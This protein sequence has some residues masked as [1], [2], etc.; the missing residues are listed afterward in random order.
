MAGTSAVF[1]AA[2]YAGASPVERD[3]PQWTAQELHLDGV[4]PE[5]HHLSPMATVLSLEGLEE[6]DPPQPG[7]VRLVQSLG[8]EFVYWQPVRGWIQ[9]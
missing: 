9:R 6:Y 1:L 5:L 2:D 3:G 8:V 4:W 7:D